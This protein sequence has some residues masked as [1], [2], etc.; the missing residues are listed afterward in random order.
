[1]YL[2]FIPLKIPQYS[3]TILIDMSLQMNRVPFPCQPMLVKRLLYLKIQTE[4]GMAVTGS[5][6]MALRVYKGKP[7]RRLLSLYTTINQ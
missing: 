6:C 2:P 3:P 7:G 5:T 1:M 4:R